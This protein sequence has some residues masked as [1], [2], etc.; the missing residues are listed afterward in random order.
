MP[1]IKRDQTELEE[2]EVW[3]QASLAEVQV[4][5]LCLQEEA[6]F[7]LFALFFLFPSTSP[8][9]LVRRAGCRMGPGS[10]RPASLF[11]E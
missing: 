11:Q 6:F 2:V 1:L 3:F 7:P 5:A 9:L 4:V 10:G 8:P